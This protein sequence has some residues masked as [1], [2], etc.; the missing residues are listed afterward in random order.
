MQSGCALTR[1]DGPEKLPANRIHDS[2]DNMNRPWRF[3]WALLLMAAPMAQAQFTCI[4]NNSNS[5][6]IAKYTGWGGAVT[7]PGSIT[8]LPV[9]GIGSNAF[10]MCYGL[11]SVT[12]T[13]SVNCIGTMAFADCLDLTNVTLPNSI[14]NIGTQAFMDCISLETVTIPGSLSSI[15]MGTFAGCMDLTNVTIANS[16]TNIGSEAF[17]DCIN[18][19]TVTIPNGVSNIAMGTFAGCTKLTNATIPD[20]VTSIGT[21][22]F[23]YCSFLP[24]VAIPGNVTNIGASAFSHCSNLTSIEI[25]ACVTNIEAQFSGAPVADVTL[26]QGVTSLGVSLFNGCTNL[27]L[28]TIPASVVNVA[29]GAFVGC[30]NLTA[31]NVAGNNPA[32]TSVAGI[33]FDAGQTTLLQYPADYDAQAYTVSNVTAIGDFAF[34]GCRRLTSVTIPGEVA[35]I[36]AE[37]LAH[38]TALTGIIVASNNPVFSSV[39]GVL[40]DKNRTTLLQCP[41]GIA[42]GLYA[43]P[44][45]VADIGVDAFDGC[46]GLT[47]IIIDLN[48]AQIGDF[49]FQSCGALTGVLFK[50]PPPAADATLFNGDT[51]ASGSSAVTAY[52]LSSES[53]WGATFAGIPTAL[54]RGSLQVTLSPPAAVTAGARWTLDGTTYLKSGATVSNLPP[55]T[56]PVLFKPISGWQTPQVLMVPVVSAAITKTN[57]VY[58][59][60]TN[61]HPVLTITSPKS[62]QTVTNASLGMTFKVVDKAPMHAVSYRLNSGAWSP[63]SYNGTSSNWTGI[64]VLN[65]G[66]NTIQAYA[67]DSGGDSSTTNSVAVQYNIFPAAQGAYFGLFAPTNAS[68]QQTNSGALT[69]TITSRGVLSGKLTIGTNTPSLAGSFNP[70]GV[71]KIVTPRKGLKTLTTILKLD[72]PDQCVEGSVGDGSFLAP[73]F[74]NLVVFNSHQPAVNYQGQYTL[75]IPGTNDPSKGPFGASYGTVTVSAS[76]VINFTGYLADGTNSVI[77]TSAVSPNGFWPMYLPLDGGGG[78]FWS[79]NCFSNGGIF[80]VSD[81][82]WIK[83]ANPASATLYQAGFT[84]EAA[85]VLGSAY[86]STNAPLLNLDEGQILLQGGGIPAISNSFIFT[87]SNAILL[88]N[89]SDT[90]GLTLTINASNGLINGSFADPSNPGQMIQVGGVLLQNQTRAAGYFPGT[91][92]SGS[93]LLM[94]P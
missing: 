5:I 38:C 74:A 52:Y 34:Y 89:A 92:Q 22:A 69:L 56:I 41:G 81:A 18:L 4:T 85:T 3:I 72:V 46:S 80:A 84:N 79:W 65:P 33:L 75:V 86:Y 2:L 63:A 83:R 82:S 19:E 61:G 28:V 10:Y 94:S 9:T 47:N 68:R 93:F 70:E 60:N 44:S 16:V 43:L 51:N 12:I 29:A 24:D 62:A 48:V 78:S 21:Y 77:L 76:G 8:G 55:G 11:T 64:V 26:D 90:N 7:I 66:T 54:W 59:K 35:S 27:S 23:E 14:T 71:A 88:T 17:M 32:Y 91:N 50:G 36:G 58:A 25:P 40:F 20:G 37:A 67:V 87:P 42:T 31:I 53:G 49:A 39:G 45:T 1:Q 13:N 57:V 30:T 15:A 73:L 6:T